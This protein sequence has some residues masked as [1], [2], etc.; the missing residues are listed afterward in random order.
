[1]SASRFAGNAGRS[2]PLDDDGSVL[3]TI[4]ELCHRSWVF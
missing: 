2:E 3:D 1:M 4:W